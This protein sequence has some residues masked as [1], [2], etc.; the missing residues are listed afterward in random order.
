MRRQLSFSLSSSAGSLSLSLSL[1]FVCLFV[2]LPLQ[3]EPLARPW[4]LDLIPFGSFKCHSLNASACEAVAVAAVVAVA[5]ASRQWNR[6]VT[7]QSIQPCDIK[8]NDLKCSFSL[9]ALS[10]AFSCECC[11][12]LSLEQ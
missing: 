7:I 10:S 2:C 11:E 12:S 1:F 3:V 4:A 5:V 9:P 8:R 6:Q